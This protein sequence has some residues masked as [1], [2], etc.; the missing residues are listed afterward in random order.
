[1]ALCGAE[2]RV[3]VKRKVHRGSAQRWAGLDD[4]SAVSL[5]EAVEEL[6]R[7]AAAASEGGAAAAAAQPSL[8]LH[9]LSL[10]MHCPALAAELQIPTFFAADLMQRVPPS[11]HSGLTEMRD[12]WPSLFAGL[13]GPGSGLHADFLDTSAWMVLLQGEKHWRVAPPTQRAAL[14]ESAERANL[15]R[16]DLFG[17][18]GGDGEGLAGLEYYEGFLRPGEAMH[19]LA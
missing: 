16:G 8:Q 11:T 15:F 5:G 2:T 14:L 3:S 9:D 1:M 18:D 19:V 10:P 4:G 12:Y 13:A 7:G 17:G 6:R